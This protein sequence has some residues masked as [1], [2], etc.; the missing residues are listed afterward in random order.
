MLVS[1][2]DS[3]DLH[4]ANILKSITRQSSEAD[5]EQKVVIPLLRLLGYS[6]KDWQTQ[7]A[8]NKSQLDFL[9]HPADVTVKYPPFLVIEVKAASK[10]IAQSAWQIHSYMRKSGAVL[11]LLTNGYLFRVIYNDQGQFITIAEYSQATL[12]N[13]FNVFYKLFSKKTCL[14]LIK[15][16][17]R[18]HQEVYLKFIG[19]LSQASGNEDMLGLFNKKKLA[20]VEEQQPRERLT[21]EQVT[22]SLVDISK[23]N[24]NS[25]IITVFNNKG[26][27]GK[28]TT[29]INLAAALNKLGKRVLLIDIDAQANLTTGLGVDPLE[30]VEL[31]GKKDITHLLTEPRTKLEDTI[32]KKRWQDVELHLVP[33]HIRLSRMES[34]LIQTVDSDRLLA[35][36][37]KK[38]DYDF[39]LIDPPPSFG[40][41][42]GISLMASSAILIPTQ[43]S[44]YPVRALEYVLDRTNEVEQLKDEPLPILGIAV[45]M[46]DQRSCSFNLSMTERLF[47]VLQRSGGSNR[48]D[49][50]PESTWIP[51]LN[52][53]SVS[54][55]KGYPLYQAEFDDQLTSQE[56]EAAQKALERYINLAQHLIKVTQK[57]S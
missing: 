47:D 3:K 15:K 25:M 34:T 56:K 21:T 5:V 51:R 45:S 50:F 40:K 14:I 9:V 54:Q 53:I 38:H 37:L 52:I 6:D 35:K 20:Y 16:L 29:T 33:S 11:G 10:K 2:T 4:L 46:Y 39:V 1:M 27:V 24:P 42:N 57:E 13:E 49:L 18:S 23:E 26:G 17:Y 30:D 31:Q 41:V 12:I 28:T 8:I 36:K 43:L 44:A 48:V 32:F 19:F 55:D 7:V 22:R